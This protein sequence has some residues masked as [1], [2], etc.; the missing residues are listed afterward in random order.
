MIALQSL[1]PGHGQHREQ[2]LEVLQHGRRGLLPVPSPGL[3]ISIF[4]F[5]FSSFPFLRGLFE[6]L[7]GADVETGGLS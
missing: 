2:Q 4:V 7:S 6:Y 3:M 5:R 1:A